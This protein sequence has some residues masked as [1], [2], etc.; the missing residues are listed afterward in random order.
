MNFYQAKEKRMA[1]TQNGP[2]CINYSCCIRVL[3]EDREEEKKGE[4][5]KKYEGHLGDM[6]FT[7]EGKLGR[8]QLGL[9]YNIFSFSLQ[10]SYCYSLSQSNWNFPPVS[11]EE[12]V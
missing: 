5:R 9:V 8:F 6:T 3:N 1:L 12:T 10:C 11:K 4:S 7:E 2:N